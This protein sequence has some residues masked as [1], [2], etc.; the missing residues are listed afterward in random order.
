MTI[1]TEEEFIALVKK[2]EEE[3]EDNPK[4]YLFKLALFALLGY[5]VIFLVLLSL[6]GLTGAVLGSA[7][8]SASLFLLL[9]KKKLIFVVLGGIW[10][11]LKALWVKFVPPEGHTLT[12]DS[13]PHLFKEIDA[14][15]K[16]L[17][18]LKIHEVILDERYNASVYQHPRLGIFGWHKNYLMLGYELMLTVSPEEMRA[19][20]AHEFGHLS[21][22]HSRF[23]GWIYRI[24]QTWQ[25]IM[26]AF[27]GNDSWGGHLMA[28][29]FNWY[30]PIFDAH[31][32]ALARKNEYEADAVSAKLTS[33]EIATTALVNTHATAPYVDESYWTHFFK[34]ADQQEKPPHAP[35]AGLNQFLSKNPIAKQ[36]ML[37]RVKAEMQRETHYSDTHP[38]L[39]DRLKAIGAK[40]QLPKAPTISA[41]E[42]WL[43]KQHKTIMKMF[44]R[45]WMSKNKQAWKER[46]EYVSKAQRHL[47]DCADK[48]NDALEDQALWDYAYWSLEFKTEA[49][50]LPLF[51]TYQ[52]RHPDDPNPAFYIGRILL[53]Q[54]DDNGLT[55]L[56]KA[57][58]SA[59]WIEDVAHIGYDYLKSQGKEQEADAWWEASV[60]D[61]EIFVKAR[62]E[63]DA[64]SP[65]DN[66][67]MPQLDAKTKQSI[68]RQLTTTGAVKKAW[69][70]EKPM[71]IFPEDRVMVIAI[72]PKGF[73]FS[74]ESIAD[75]AGEQLEVERITFFIVPD[76]DDYKPIAKN[77]KKQG[78]KLI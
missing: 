33:P 76:S 19:I 20:L 42:K 10:V 22:N 61:N 9:L 70:A 72:K 7:L 67:V 32:F 8:I 4:W 65:D 25:R 1:N 62:E 47:T 18:A 6:I 43:G 17:N 58:K 41:A 28:K 63:R 31:S 49:D 34:F 71:E 11:L 57:R 68:I 69:I 45:E 39:K 13:H 44:D 46:Y 59:Y 3:A 5:V 2:Y 77:V 51:K 60:K 16:E 26:F 35:Y 50:A 40:P 30:S 14:L 21:G 74:A 53:N 29:F 75:K 73:G 23:S 48:A 27:E 78:M 15:S 24:R 56:K 38:S 37:A 36:E 66:L 55:E 52:Q 64:V 12:R 54:Q